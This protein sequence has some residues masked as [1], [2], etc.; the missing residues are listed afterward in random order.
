M[1]DKILLAAIR[2]LDADAL[3]AV[4]E[5]YAPLVF[6]YSLRLCRDPQE[7]DDVVGEVFS[8]LLDALT[9]GKGPQK[10]LR[11]YLYQTA[12][13]IIIDDTRDR[14]HYTPLDGHF[15]QPASEDL[16][17]EQ[18]EERRQFLLLHKAIHTVLTQD[19]KHVIV[20]RFLEGFDLR[21]TAHIL[22]RDVNNIKVIQNR[23]V[24]K[25]RE[26]LLYET[27]E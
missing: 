18:A 17:P 26:A 15:N 27:R 5:Q 21:D 14:T 24:A 23:A 1:D 20:L 11:S 2:K 22:G 8:R 19:Q 25:L 7:A 12:Y 10:N 6:K 16:P 9:Q 13:H 4:F 3:T